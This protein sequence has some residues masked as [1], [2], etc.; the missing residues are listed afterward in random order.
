MSYDEI[1]VR[2]GHGMPIS[3][4]VHSSFVEV[5]DLVSFE[6]EGSVLEVRSNWKV[7]KIRRCATPSDQ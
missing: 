2:D 5:Q 7:V 4:N 3:Y 6:A 1:G